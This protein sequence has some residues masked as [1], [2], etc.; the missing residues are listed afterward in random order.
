MTTKAQEAL[1]GAFR[2][3]E[4]ESNQELGVWHLL[5]SML[6]AGIGT[7]DDL[8]AACGGDTAV[9]YDKAQDE[10][11]RVPRIEG[12][13]N[14]QPTPSRQLRFVLDSAEAQAKSLGDE[15]VASEHLLLG[16]T[17]VASPA[18]DA[19]EAQGV[20]LSAIRQKLGD[21]RG[22]Q[23]ADSPD[24]EDKYKVLEKY[25]VDLTQRARDGKLDPVIGRD[26]EIRRVIRILSRRTKNNPVLIG[27]PGTGKTAIAEGLAQ[28]I[29]AGDIPESLRDR[30]VWS[31]DLGALIAG[32]KFRGEFEERLKAVLKE[33]TQS[34][35]RIIVFIDEIHTLVGAGKSEG[36]MDAGNLMKPMLAR[37]ELR[38][39]GATTLDE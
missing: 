14:L 5:A 16:L 7:A 15:Y 3:A 4:R 35:G 2:M 25:G 28:R 38:V 22:A 34:D 21:V 33:V 31:L 8:I 37:G 9:L 10:V 29:A 1:A 6:K 17:D 39:V 11:R 26:E 30:T 23:H 19:L 32:A 20:T 18:K 24:A 12:A 27:E 36:S 13:E